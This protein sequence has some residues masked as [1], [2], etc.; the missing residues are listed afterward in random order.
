[1]RV[2]LTIKESSHGLWCIRGGKA[3][4]YDQLR[5]AQAIRLARGLAREE[6]AS[7]GRTVSVELTCAEFTI[8]LVQYAAPGA[9]RRIAA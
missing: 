2:V 6:H 9:P 7:S 8:A 1:M 5:F 4:L 3:L